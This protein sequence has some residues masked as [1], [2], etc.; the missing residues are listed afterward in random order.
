MF[1]FIRMLRV[2]DMDVRSLEWILYF[3]VLFG[4]VLVIMVKSGDVMNLR[5][6]GLVKLFLNVICILIGV[7]LFYEFWLFYY[8]M[9]LGFEF[10]FRER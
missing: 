7:F 5:R 3:L 10:L 9:V 1:L 6:E 4:E 2:G 8:G